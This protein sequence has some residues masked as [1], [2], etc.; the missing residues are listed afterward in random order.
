M[1]VYNNQSVAGAM[2]TIL[3]DGKL[4]YSGNLRSGE[5]QIGLEAGGYLWNTGSYKGKIGVRRNP[6]SH[7]KGFL[8]CVQNLSQK[9]P[10]A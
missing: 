2:T 7:T 3:V 5:N 4:A 8:F 10:E 9:Q 6:T 1:A